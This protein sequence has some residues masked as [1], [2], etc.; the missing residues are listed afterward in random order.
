MI[1][2]HLTPQEL[3]WLQRN[4]I[5]H[6]IRQQY[7]SIRLKHSKAK[8]KEKKAPLPV[9]DLPR[10]LEYC[11]SYDP[12]ARPTRD[13][14]YAAYQNFCLSSTVETPIRFGKQLR[15]LLSESLP[16]V[17][18]KVARRQ[19]LDG[20]ALCYVGLN[21]K[22]DTAPSDGIMTQPLSEAHILTKVNCPKSPQ[23]EHTHPQFQDVCG[24]SSK[25]LCSSPS[26]CSSSSH[27]HAQ[28]AQFGNLFHNIKQPARLVLLPNTH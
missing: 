16:N 17:E 4:L 2:F 21:V 24:L 12:N 5:L 22:Q 28:R 7:P 25:T 18:Y 26:V 13:E 3:T 14:V 9:R 19:D 1:N 15:A 6:G 27:L 23:T 10:F 20:T 11:C 8:S